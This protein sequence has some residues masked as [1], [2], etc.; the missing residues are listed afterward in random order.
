MPHIP[1]PDSRTLREK[2]TEN[3][4]GR[5]CDVYIYNETFS[6]GWLNPFDWI[7]RA[8]H[9]KEWQARLG[10]GTRTGRS[11]Q[12]AKSHRV[13]QSGRQDVSLTEKV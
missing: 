9:G 5:E 11:G 10:R 12:G 8:L 1:F 7:V 2:R 13:R 6:A 4:A 3:I